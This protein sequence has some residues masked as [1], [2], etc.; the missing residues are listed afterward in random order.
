MGNVFFIPF[1]TGIMVSKTL[2][3]SVKIIQDGS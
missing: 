2:I 3:S 1:K